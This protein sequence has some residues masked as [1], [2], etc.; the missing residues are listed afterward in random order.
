MDFFKDEFLYRDL[1][2]KNSPQGNDPES[3]MKKSFR[4]K[5]KA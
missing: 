2:L 3:A 5:I 1:G 4:K